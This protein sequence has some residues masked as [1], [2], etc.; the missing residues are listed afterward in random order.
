MGRGISVCSTNAQ[1]TAGDSWYSSNIIHPTYRG[2]IGSN[3]KSPPM[4]LRVECDVIGLIQGLWLYFRNQIAQNS[5]LD[6]SCIFFIRTD[7]FTWV[8][9]IPGPKT[10][11]TL[12]RLKISEGGNFYKVIIISWICSRLPYVSRKIVHAS[13]IRKHKLVSKLYQDE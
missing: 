6:E 9:R 13:I 10:R 1:N 5:H 3:K 7:D 12:P 4:G 11:A 2:W 8:P